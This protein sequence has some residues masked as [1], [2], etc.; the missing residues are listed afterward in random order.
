[1]DHESG[2]IMVRSPSR[3]GFI[4]GLISFV[5]APAIVRASS[6]M[7]IKALETEFDGLAASLALTKEIIAANIF[8][9][10]AV[11]DALLPGLFEVRM[12]YDVLPSAWETL[13]ASSGDR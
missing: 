3:R 1:M 8:N 13:F 2:A 11:R 9:L 12:S 6:L 7:P 10:G 5:A 4:S